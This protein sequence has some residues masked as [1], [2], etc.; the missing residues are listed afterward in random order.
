LWLF[1]DY[2]EVQGLSL[3]TAVFNPDPSHHWGHTCW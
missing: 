2:L 1:A 3:A